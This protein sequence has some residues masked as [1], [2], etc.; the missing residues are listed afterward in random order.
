MWYIWKDYIYI[1]IYIYIMDW[2]MAP[3]SSKSDWSWW[4]KGETPKKLD[5]TKL[6]LDLIWCR[7]QIDNTWLDEKLTLTWLGSCPDFG[8]VNISQCVK[9]YNI[10]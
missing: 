3:V 1:Y 2:E 8:Q 9:F 5:L 4:W 10:M 7:K 6:W